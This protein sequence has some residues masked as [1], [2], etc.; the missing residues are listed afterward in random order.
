[1]ART[2][3]GWKF[4]SVPTQWL[5]DNASAI[6]VGCLLPGGELEQAIEVN[7]WVG[8]KVAAL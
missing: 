4:P 7:I 3:I 2:F 6:G 1:V 5:V 8:F